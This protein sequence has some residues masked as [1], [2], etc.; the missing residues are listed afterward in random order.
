M[1]P[2]V[3][4]SLAVYYVETSR[5]RCGFASLASDENVRRLRRRSYADLEGRLGFPR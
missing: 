5:A 2:S 3:D 4:N 1:M